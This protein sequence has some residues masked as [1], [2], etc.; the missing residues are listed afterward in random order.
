MQK[1]VREALQLIDD[2][3]QLGLDKLAAN[4]KSSS[5]LNTYDEQQIQA[6]VTPYHQRGQQVYE[7]LAQCLKEYAP[8]LHSRPY[9]SSSMQITVTGDAQGAV[10]IDMTPFGS[11]V[12]VYTYD[13]LADQV[14]KSIN[15]CLEHCGLWQ[16]TQS[17]IDEIRTTGQYYSLF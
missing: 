12:A 1:E 16:L 14:R 11:F 7:Q 3:V 15:H 8:E 6:L 4:T 5:K 10:I 17:E 13:T 2:I 9:S